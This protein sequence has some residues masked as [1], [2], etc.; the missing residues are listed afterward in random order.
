IR[1]A[2]FLSMG[3]IA[4]KGT[5]GGI[6]SMNCEGPTKFIA[7]GSMDVKVEGKN[8]QLLSDQMLNN[9]GPT[10]S[11]ANSATMAGLLQQ[12]K[13]K[14]PAK[15]CVCGAGKHSESIQ[16]PNVPKKEWHPN[17]RLAAMR[18]AAT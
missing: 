9:C 18:E 15:Y 11:P 14:N 3:D 6:V 2:T 5:G 7:P 16:K 17:K 1:G 13:A 12:A 4:S 8:V 10:G